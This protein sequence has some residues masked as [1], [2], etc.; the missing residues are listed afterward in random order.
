MPE[1]HE[2]EHKDD[3]GAHLVDKQLEDMNIF[4]DGH[5]HERDPKLYV[6]VNIGAKS[7]MQRIVVFEG[8]TPKELAKQFCE[9]HNLNEEMLSKLTTLL[10]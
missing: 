2:P 8:D 10:Q 5:E 3:D 6:D 1:H 9:K 4:Q 7:G